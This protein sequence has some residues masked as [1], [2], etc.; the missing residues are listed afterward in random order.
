[1]QRLLGHPRGG[2]LAVVG[3]IER[4]WECSIEWPESGHRT[5]VFADA[6]DRLLRGYP[7]G[8]AMQ[9]FGE[10]YAELSSD[11]SVELAAMVHGGGP[12]E[13]TLAAMWTACN[14]ARNYTVV[15]DPAVRL[16]PQLTASTSQ[17]SS[18]STN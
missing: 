8:A 17:F 13:T 12:D 10:R 9:P 15:G 18:L 16:S 3:H 11:L 2:A 14:D 6:L 1:P 5:G 4:A 7:I